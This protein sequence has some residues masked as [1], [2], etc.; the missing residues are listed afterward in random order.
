MNRFI[1][2]VIIVA[3]LTGCSINNSKFQF[4]SKSLNIQCPITLL[5]G[6]AE[7]TKVTC[8]AAKFQIDIT[9]HEKS[10]VSASSLRVLDD[11]YSK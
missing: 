4:L 5:D 1:C 10:P 2:V 6:E 8:L 7:L 3:L 9:L 11:D